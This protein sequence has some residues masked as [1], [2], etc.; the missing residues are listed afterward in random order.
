MNLFMLDLR[1][2]LIH[3]K[4]HHIKRST[5]ITEVCEVDILYTPCSAWYLP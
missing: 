1:F 4:L 5:N 2:V 3:A